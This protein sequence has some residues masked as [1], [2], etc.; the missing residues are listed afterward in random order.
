MIRV[1]DLAGCAA[2]MMV[3]LMTREMILRVFDM[4]SHVT[5]AVLV[6]AVCLLPALSPYLILLPIGALRLWDM[7]TGPSVAQS[8]R[9]ANECSDPL[10]CGPK[11][12][13]IAKWQSSISQLLFRKEI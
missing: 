3:L 6:I 8:S 4:L 5:G 10:L 7:L 9:R 12:S 1:I 2:P 11:V 13:E